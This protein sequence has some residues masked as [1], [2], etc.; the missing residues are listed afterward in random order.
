MATDDIAVKF[1]N[2]Y[3]ATGEESVTSRSGVVQLDKLF[4]VFDTS[5]TRFVSITLNRG[6]YLFI[7]LNLVHFSL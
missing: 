3:E 7:P 1:L 6:V 5:R 2:F 4:S